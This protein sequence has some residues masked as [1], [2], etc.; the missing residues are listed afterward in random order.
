MP[1][2]KRPKPA[3][4]FCYEKPKP[5]KNEYAVE[6]ETFDSLTAYWRGEGCDLDWNCIFVLPSWLKVWWTFF[7][8]GWSAYPISI[9]HRGRPIGIAPLM[10][11]GKSARVMGS[12][13]VCD[14]LDLIIAPGRERE[15]LK[16]L[17]EHLRREGITLLDLGPLRADA[18]LLADI[19]P[20]A[21]ELGYETTTD[22]E[23]ITLEMELPPTWD[24][25]LLR[26]TGKQRHEIRRKLKRLNEGAQIA[27]RVIEKQAEVREEIKIFLALFR[28][29]RADKAAFMTQQMASF[30]ESLAE[31]MA[32]LE[33]LK[34]FFLEIDARPAA[35]AMC[36][37]DGAKVYLYNNG[38]DHRFRS[39]SVGLLCKVLSIRASIER[40]R[41][42][43]DF[44]KG[45]EPYKYFLGGEPVSL[46]RCKVHMG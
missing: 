35:A 37:D 15:V 40:G 10:V 26:I 27:Y 45:P 19:A 36:F 43:F 34:L 39:L 32:Q 33:M 14:F 17:L 22:L 42:R 11:N 41:K 23:D 28:S 4:P 38:Y 44:L 20:A 30:F 31:A 29:N 5:M 12:S 8:K 6:L 7:G 2:Q 21:K 13:D 9:K 16:I 25:Y 46:Y 3:I 1:W 18:P 24:D